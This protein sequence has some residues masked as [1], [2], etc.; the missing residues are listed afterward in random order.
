M[1]IYIY[2]YILV[3]NTRGYICVINGLENVGFLNVQR[4]LI[5]L[6]TVSNTLN[7]DKVTSEWFY[8]EVIKQSLI[9]DRIRDV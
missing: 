5:H 1:I 6:N 3:A 9:Q 7:A 2:I 8:S 4:F